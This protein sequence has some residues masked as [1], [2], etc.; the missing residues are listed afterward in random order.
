MKISQCEFYNIALYESTDVSDTAQ[1]SVFTRGVTN[2]FEV[3]EELLEMCPMKGTITGQHIADEVNMLKIQNRSP[4]KLC[5][6]TTDG[7][8]AITGIIKGF[9][10]FFMGELGVKKSDI[11]INHCTINQENLSSNVLGFKDIVK[12]VVQSV[13]FIQSR[14]LNHR[15]FKAMLD[16]LDSEYG[17]LVYFLNVCWL[18]R[19]AT[20]KRFGDLKSKIKNFMKEKGQDVTFFDDKKFLT[21]LA[22]LVDVNQH[23]SD[24]NLKL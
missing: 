6:I 24:L 22:F 20:L 9:T 14:A 7:A 13:N 12:K 21:G 11:V 4:K 17:D 23:L 10:K 18:S 15:Q 19:A 1:L 8:A 3:I 5:G 2:N 16:E